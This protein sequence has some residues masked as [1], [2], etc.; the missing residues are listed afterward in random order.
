MP[1]HCR[2]NRVKMVKGMGSRGWGGGGEMRKKERV[3]GEDKNCTFTT[4][5]YTITQSLKLHTVTHL[6][7]VYT[8]SFKFKHLHQYYFV[9][10][11]SIAP[12]K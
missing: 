5:S 8:K 10:L 12:I 11:S 4:K 7:A 9:F 1:E 6:L 3:E 2:G